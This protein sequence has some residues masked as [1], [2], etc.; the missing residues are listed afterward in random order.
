MKDLFADLFLL[1]LHLILLHFNLIL[2]KILLVFKMINLLV[3]EQLFNSMSRF[4]NFKIGETI[5]LVFF[6]SF[7]LLFHLILLK[8]FDFSCFKKK[9]LLMLKMINLLVIKRLFNSRL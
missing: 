9:I 3:I 8:V 4:N 7:V 1:L 6:G 2:K 5:I